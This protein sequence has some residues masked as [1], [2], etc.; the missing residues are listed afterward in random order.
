MNLKNEMTNVADLISKNIGANC[1]L[2]LQPIN[3]SLEELGE[4]SVYY[5]A[6]FSS[7]T[8]KDLLAGFHSASL[9]TATYI[10][11]GL[12]RA[13]LSAIRLQVDLLLGFSFFCDHPREWEKLVTTGEGFK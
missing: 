6:N 5:Q 1:D 8:S 13:A 2:Y 7:S 10:C 11:L 3:R 9:E 4:W 12:S